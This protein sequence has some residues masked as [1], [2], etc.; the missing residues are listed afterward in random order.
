LDLVILQ[1]DLELEAHELF[2]VLALGG[3]L[4]IVELRTKFLDVR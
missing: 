4:Q 3:F 2:F 1:L